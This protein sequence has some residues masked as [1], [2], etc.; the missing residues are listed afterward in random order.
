MVYLNIYGLIQ[1]CFGITGF[2]HTEP[3]SQ[4]SPKEFAY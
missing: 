2:I 1:Y 3:T 4:V